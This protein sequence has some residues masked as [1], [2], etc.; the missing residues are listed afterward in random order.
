MRFEMTWALLLVPEIASANIGF[1]VPYPPGL[2]GIGSFGVAT[3]SDPTATDHYAVSFLS[4][5]GT[6]T[7][8]S[9]T[10]AATTAP[11][12]TANLGLPPEVDPA[13][14][15]YFGSWVQAVCRRRLQYATN[16]A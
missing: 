13:P 5:D 11:T 12:C 6:V 9:R 2:T 1:D 3:G 4:P 15:A 14:C 8:Q 16:V 7:V 10:L